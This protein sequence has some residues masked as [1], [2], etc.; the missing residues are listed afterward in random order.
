MSRMLKEEFTNKK[1]AKKGEVI[2]FHVEVT[3]G[4]HRGFQTGQITHHCQGCPHI[5]LDLRL[6]WWVRG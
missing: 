4:L 5:W 1:G 2:K 3:P 6:P